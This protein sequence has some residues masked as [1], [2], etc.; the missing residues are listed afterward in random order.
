VFYFAQ[1]SNL[2]GLFIVVGVPIICHIVAKFCEKKKEL[3]STPNDK[4]ILG[5]G[6]T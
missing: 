6:F 2:I 3:P 5:W 4:V 1:R